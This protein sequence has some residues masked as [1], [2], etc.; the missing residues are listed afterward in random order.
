MDMI[1]AGHGVHLR[2]AAQAPE[3]T[4]KD[5]AIVIF[6]KRAAA[7]FFRAVKDLA[8]ALSVEQGGPIQSTSPR[9]M[10]TLSVTIEGAA[11]K[12]WQRESWPMQ[13]MS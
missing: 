3:R 4:G 7:K 9:L 1:V 10:R 6:V 13:G 11:R 12:C 2:L 5:D 8:K